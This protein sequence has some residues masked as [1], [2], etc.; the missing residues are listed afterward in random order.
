MKS[1][2]LLIIPLAFCMGLAACRTDRKTAGS[3]STK[4]KELKLP[5][6]PQAACPVPACSILHFATS[7]EKFAYISPNT[8]TPCPP[9]SA[10]LVNHGKSCIMP[11]RT[12]GQ[13]SVRNATRSLRCSGKNCFISSASS[14]DS[15]KS[16]TFALH[17]SI[18][19]PALG[20]FVKPEVAGTEC[21]PYI[22][23]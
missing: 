14:I 5:D 21:L 18:S 15:V 11:Y 1:A 10:V 12:S 7:R 22:F 23:P 16:P 13:H 8:P 9:P 20:F 2:A 4:E 6:F 19:T 17:H 3:V